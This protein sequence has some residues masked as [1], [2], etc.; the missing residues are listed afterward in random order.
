MMFQCPLSGLVGCNKMPLHERGIQPLFQCPLSGLVGCNED[1]FSAARV[2]DTFQCPLSG[3]V[4]CNA[5]FPI[6]TADFRCFNA[7]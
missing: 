5:R 3:L 4:G 7:L 2:Y 1:G 6:T